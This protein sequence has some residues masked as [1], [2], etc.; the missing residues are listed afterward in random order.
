MIEL[1]KIQEL[2]VKKRGD[3]GLYLGV[4]GEEGQIVFLPNSQ[5]KEGEKYKVGKRLEVFIYKDSDGRMVATQKRPLLE[6]GEIGMVKVVSKT[7]IGAFLDWGLDKDLFL[8]FREQL[9]NINEDDEIMI[10]PYIDKTE[11]IAATMKI[12][13]KLQ[14]E[15]PYKENQEVVGI[16]Y[17]IKKDLGVMIA[18][19]SKYHGLIHKEDVVHDFKIGQKV[20]AKVLK[21]RK[22]G[23]L[24]LNTTGKAYKAIDKN[25]K[26]ILNYLKENNG[27]ILLHD[28][29]NPDEIKELLN[30]SKNSFKKAIGRLYKEGKI[31][32]KENS[33]ELKNDI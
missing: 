30:M 17:D 14:S 26:K 18:V 7:K 8:P 33:I 22:D 28:K 13:N 32:L 3:S 27:V 2:I 23:K 15:N 4:E 29:S 25:S 16:V 9:G 31:I 11:R 10:M 12:Y 1:G 24:D 19:D 6:I 20:T 5:E 21:K